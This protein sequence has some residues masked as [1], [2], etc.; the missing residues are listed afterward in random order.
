MFLANISQ[1]LLK[2]Q[3]HGASG[4]QCM[5]HENSWIGNMIGSWG[6]EPSWRMRFSTNRCNPADFIGGDFKIA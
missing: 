1:S 4:M 2:A 5:P 6:I 3:S